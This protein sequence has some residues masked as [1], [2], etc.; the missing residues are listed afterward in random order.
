MEKIIFEIRNQIFV[1]ITLCKDFLQ[2]TNW[3]FVLGVGVISYI[4]F[5]RHWDF[6]KLLSF[7]F[8]LFLLFIL[9]VRTEAFIKTA[10][11]ASESFFILGV[12]RGVF[13][14]IAAAVLIYHVA[15]KD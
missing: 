5:L 10:L 8:V 4:L 9:L 15:I 3:F 13:G 6:K 11:K 12:E 7:L 2:G 1:T 14:I